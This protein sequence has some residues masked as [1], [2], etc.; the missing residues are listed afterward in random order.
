MVGVFNVAGEGKGMAMEEGVRV[1]EG[2]MRMW[3]REAL[4][5]SQIGGKHLFGMPGFEEME[6]VG[7]RS[8]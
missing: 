5:R 8:G 1:Y 6:E 2:K 7:G 4:V 3:A